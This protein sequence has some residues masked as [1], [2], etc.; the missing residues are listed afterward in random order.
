LLNE[1]HVQ[2]CSLGCSLFVFENCGDILAP[3]FVKFPYRNNELALRDIENRIQR[4]WT[5]IA[6]IHS[7]I[8]DLC[9]YCFLF[10]LHSPFKPMT[11][12]QLFWILTILSNLFTSIRHVERYDRFLSASANRL[13]AVLFQIRE[14]CNQFLREL[15]ICHAPIRQG[16][17]L[18]IKIWWSCN[19]RGA[20]G[21][22]HGEVDCHA[23]AD[24]IVFGQTPNN[25]A[26][27]WTRFV[28]GSRCAAN[29]M[30]SYRASVW[31]FIRCRNI[32]KEIQ[33]RS[34]RFSNW[35]VHR[36]WILR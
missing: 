4:R 34:F 8:Q 30:V 3:I 7:Q 16:A 22:P 1:I 25:W 26:R 33:S 23:R 10:A 32:G 17:S 14:K 29:W 28:S 19:S 18:D 12:T 13:F 36:F 35:E 31:S 20:S 11:P 24:R 6:S 27:T 9:M 5:P 15:V 21:L 2:F